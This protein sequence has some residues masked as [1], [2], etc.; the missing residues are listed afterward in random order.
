MHRRLLAMVVLA[1]AEIDDPMRASALPLL[2]ALSS[3]IPSRATAEAPPRPVV[4][5]TNSGSDSISVIDGTTNTVTST[6]TVGDAVRKA[7]LALSPDGT[8]AYLANLERNVISVLDTA[9]RRVIQTIPISEPTAVAF[10]PDG[11]FAYV[12][13][14]QYCSI[15]VVLDTSTHTAVKTLPLGG[16][17]SVLAFSHD[18]AAAYIAV[19]DP[20][21]DTGDTVYK[22]D[23]HAHAL[24]TAP[25]SVPTK[26]RELIPSA[27][28]RLLYVKGTD[29]RSDSRDADFNT[30][31]EIDVL[32]TTTRGIVRTFALEDLNGRA[33]RK[34]SGGS[35]T[36][37]GSR[38]Y[39]VR[40][41]GV[42]VIDIATNTVVTT[43]TL[44]QQPTSVVMSPDGAAAYI[45]SEGR[46]L[47]VLD[48]AA[49]TVQAV[50][51]ISG[52][53]VDVRVSP[54]GTHL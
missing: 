54:D 15:L 39:A 26:V 5:V 12:L 31:I 6:I 42:R 53:P 23:V 19:S 28:D 41:G 16:Q 35:F 13:S 18:G 29:P 44:P 51:P 9:T 2:L 43:V 50:I 3:A 33:G 1:A 37:D 4:Y 45:A 47:T 20:Y 52:N 38:F 32:D 24:A 46:E 30:T 21:G 7:R 34:F 40:A 27:D 11:R 49:N 48:T 22:V 17:S 14:G 36:A 10:T 25:E 8:L